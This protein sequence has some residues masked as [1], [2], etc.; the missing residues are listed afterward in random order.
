MQ[1]EWAS[2]D[3]QD[4]PMKEGENQAS[5]SEDMEVDLQALIEVHGEKEVNN[6]QVAQLCRLQRELLKR[7][8]KEPNTCNLASSS[9]KSGIKPN[10]LKN[11]K[12]LGGKE[13]KKVEI[14]KNKFWKK[15]ELSL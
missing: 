2:K 7:K 11:S 9:R 3:S 8:R 15:H 12:K 14:H 1:E 5:N 6:M 13:K 4:E 10:P